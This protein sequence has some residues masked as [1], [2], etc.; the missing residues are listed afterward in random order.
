MPALLAARERLSEALVD[1]V[2]TASEP[3]T[4]EP[5]RYR[6]RRTTTAPA[7]PVAERARSGRRDARGLPRGGARSAGRRAG[8]LGRR[9]CTSRPTWSGSRRCGAP[10]TRSRAARGWS[11]CASS[12]TPP[13]PASRS[14]TT[15]LVDKRPADPGRCWTSPRGRS[16]RLG[17]LDRCHR[18]GLAARYAAFAWPSSPAGRRRSAAKQ[19]ASRGAASSRGG[20]RRPT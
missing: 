19:L 6:S 2:H 13:G 18:T 1:F 11:A 9:W 20:W 10:S 7:A 3:G 12:A 14:T 17:Q 8:R 5:D 15:R 16:T 4:L